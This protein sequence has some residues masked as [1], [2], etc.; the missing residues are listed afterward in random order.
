MLRER[1]EGAREEAVSAE[2]ARRDDVYQLHA[3]LARDRSHVRA[4][5]A[6]RRRDQRAVRRRVVRVLDAHRHADPHRRLHCHRVQHLRAKVSQFGRLLERD[7]RH[8]HG[9]GAD[10]R[11]GR[12]DAVDVLPHL[13]LVV[14]RRRANQ[15][16]RQVRSA[17]PKRR[18]RPSLVLA[19][20]T[21]DHGDRSLRHL[22]ESAPD[23]RPRRVEHRR[24]AKLGRRHQPELPRLELH[25]G[26]ADRSQLRGDHPA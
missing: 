21:G 6:A 10:A 26:H 15:R 23:R 18:D 4:R 7:A 11:V 1:L 9:R 19:D 20:E 17:A 14:A 2:H 12:Q 8:R 3:L 13:H 22:F 16:R 25:R 24:V 5:R